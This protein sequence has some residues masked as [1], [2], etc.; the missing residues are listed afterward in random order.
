[1]ISVLLDKLFAEPSNA[2]IVKSL[3]Y[4]GEHLASSADLVFSRL[5]L[6]AAGQ[7]E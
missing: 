5:L 4:M 2:V 7:S 3:S 6:Y 1:M